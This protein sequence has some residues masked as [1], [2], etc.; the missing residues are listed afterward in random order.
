MNTRFL[1][2][3]LIVL[4]AV[5]GARGEESPSLQGSVDQNEVSPSER[6]SGNTIPAEVMDMPAPALPGKV[7]DNGADLGSE[8]GQMG[9]YTPG[10]PLRATVKKGELHGNA[11]DG[12]PDLDNMNGVM[13][14]NG[15]L[16][17][18]ANK[19]DLSGLGAMDPDRDD[20]ELM[21]E[22]DKWR[23][24]LNWAVQ[25]ALM[26]DANDPDKMRAVWNP[27]T[28][29]MIMVPR[30]PLGLTT[31]Y[32]LRVDNKKHITGLELVRSSGNP[33]Y[34]QAVLDAVRSLN[35]TSILKFPARSQRL[36]VRQVTGI[37]TS[38]TG[39][40]QFHKFGDVER[41]RVP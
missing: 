31:W 40:R 12:N 1:T 14:Q 27:Q 20:Q 23:N 11:E 16:K 22:W 25:G 24:R 18:N 3:L 2:L 26:A 37:K 33:E 34:D 41:Y 39:G 28:Q 5:P 35:R 8:K 36:K 30:F 15:M 6:N 19:D 13:D 29:T 10:Q 32:D 17:G 4:L 38:L 9:D 21:V 7:E